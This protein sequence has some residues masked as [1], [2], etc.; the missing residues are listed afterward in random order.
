MGGG[1]G[2]WRFDS[3]SSQ[4][5]KREWLEWKVI[6]LINAGH[7]KKYARERAKHLYR[8]RSR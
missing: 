7:T 3:R 8:Q 2:N 4:G 1:L 6:Q 5:M